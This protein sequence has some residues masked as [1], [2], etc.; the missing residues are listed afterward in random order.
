MDSLAI[1][2]SSLDATTMTGLS[3]EILKIMSTTFSLVCFLCLKESTCETRRNVFYFTSKAFFV[4]E[5][6]KF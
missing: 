5:I 4:L 3:M 1:W 6:M 2:N